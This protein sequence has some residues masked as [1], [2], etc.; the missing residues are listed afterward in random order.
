MEG[1][2]LCERHDSTVPPNF[3]RGTMYDSG[4]FH[5]PAALEPRLPLKNMMD[6]PQ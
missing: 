4:Q 3:N 6:K 2:C 1:T 5:A